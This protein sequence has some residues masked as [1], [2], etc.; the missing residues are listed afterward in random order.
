MPEPSG[1]ADTNACTRSMRLD[2]AGIDVFDF[3]AQIDFYRRAFDLRVDQR[4][5]LTEY[6]FTYALLRHASGWGIELFK[7]EGAGPRPV[8]DDADHQHDVLGLGHVCFSVDDV[9]AMHDHLVALGAS[10]R[11]PPSPSL[12]P[13]IMFA[14]LADPEGNLVEL[15]DSVS[16]VKSRNGNEGTA[17]LKDPVSEHE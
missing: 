6:N 3:D 8:P 9:A 4:A 1:I 11:I 15:L 10:S 14:Y 7:R 12:V 5:V 2:H 17:R 13:E 16:G